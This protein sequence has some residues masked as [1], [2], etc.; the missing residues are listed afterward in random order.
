M[1]YSCMCNTRK[2]ISGH[3]K[4][5][6]GGQNDPIPCKCTRY[7]CPVEGKCESKGVIYQCEVKETLSGKIES[8]VGLTERTFKDRLT[9][10]RK[11]F[12]DEN[13][14]RN[15]LSKYIWQLKKAQKDFQVSWKLISS[16]KP[17]SPSSKMCELCLREIYFIM[18]YTKSKA[19]L[20]KRNEFFGH[21]LH[22]SKYLLSNQ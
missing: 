14:H 6:L 20:N 13:Y 16:A 8:Y 22:K 4:K 10:H 5:H 7:E 18:Y 19:T 12:R 21:C 17:Y 9:K 2:I 3:N 1:S 15:S 11:S